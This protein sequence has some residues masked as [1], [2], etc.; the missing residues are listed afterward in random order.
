[1]D[2]IPLH[3]THAVVLLVMLLPRIVLVPSWSILVLPLHDALGIVMKVSG[4]LSLKRR[5]GVYLKTLHD[6]LEV[7]LL[8]IYLGLTVNLSIVDVD[9]SDHFFLS[10]IGLV[11]QAPH[12]LPGARTLGTRR[13]TIVSRVVPCLNISTFITR[14]KARVSSPHLGS[15]SNVRGCLKP[16]SRL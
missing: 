12:V 10:A 13:S 11:I 7:C 14:V 1:M 9:A 6:A 16:D 8:Y 15:S 3:W 5:S 2:L 4:H